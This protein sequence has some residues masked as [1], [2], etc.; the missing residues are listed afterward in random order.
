MSLESQENT[1]CSQIQEF[2][3]HTSLRRL[4]V[5]PMI[6]QTAHQCNFQTCEED[7][8]WQML[9]W[10]PQPAIGHGVISQPDV[11][12]YNQ[13]RLIT[14]SGHKLSLITTDEKVS[15]HNHIKFALGK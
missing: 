11:F 15:Y 5:L 13:Q 9:W 8:G 14:T 12:Y 6:K 3:L 7:R 1:V 10:R 4:L 2:S